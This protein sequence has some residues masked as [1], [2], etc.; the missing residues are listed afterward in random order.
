MHRLFATGCDWGVELT[1]KQQTPPDAAASSSGAAIAGSCM[2]RL[3]CRLTGSCYPTF[4]A[5]AWLVRK[6][7]F[8]PWLSCD[9]AAAAATRCP[10]LLA[11]H[12][13][14]ATRQSP[15]RTCHA[16]CWIQCEGN[17][18]L[19]R[20]RGSCCNQQALVH[21]LWPL[22]QLVLVPKPT[23]AITMQRSSCLSLS[24]GPGCTLGHEHA[25]AMLARYTNSA[26]AAAAATHA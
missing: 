8:L 22:L 4:H 18:R 3:P 13:G 6:L 17:M 24:G 5:P 19:F 23:V 10:V 1:S 20:T 11:P 25:A 9:A 2:R 26:A 15:C 7:L 14:A 21:C 12:A 16:G